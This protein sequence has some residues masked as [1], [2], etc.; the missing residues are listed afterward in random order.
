MRVSQISSGEA[1][2]ALIESSSGD[3]AFPSSI[4]VLALGLSTTSA[5]SFEADEEPLS[6]GAL[7][8]SLRGH[9]LSA[10]HKHARVADRN[11][12]LI[13]TLKIARDLLLLA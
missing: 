6:A 2:E 10:T 8:M 4:V 7:A 5:W 13:I 1:A 9:P 12:T 11:R 3:F